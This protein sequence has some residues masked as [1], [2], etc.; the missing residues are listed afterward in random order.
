[1]NSYEPNFE[2]SRKFIDYTFIC[3]LHR[4]SFV[5]TSTI[6]PPT[7][8]F[9]YPHLPCQLPSFILIQPLHLPP[10]ISTHQ[11]FTSQQQNKITHLCCCLL[12][13]AVGAIPEIKSS[14]LQKMC[15]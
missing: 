12:L 6:N 3:R 13:V 15:W 10:Y 2:L 9:N 11:T 7:T 5:N 4:S 1:M 8:A 14:H